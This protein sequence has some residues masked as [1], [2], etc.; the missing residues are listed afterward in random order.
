[1]HISLIGVFENASRLL[2]YLLTE[3]DFLHRVRGE[4][5]QVRARCSDEGPE[6]GGVQG[7]DGAELGVPAAAADKDRQRREQDA[8]DS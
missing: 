1:M 7:L 8:R 3:T 4:A 6:L 2:R 5:G